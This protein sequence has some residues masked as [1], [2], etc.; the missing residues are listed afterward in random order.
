MMLA[1]ILVGT[2]YSVAVVL[3]DEDEGEE[4]YEREAGG[5]GGEVEES[6]EGEEELG[7]GLGSL[8]L[9]LGLIGVLGYVIYKYLYL[10]S[11]RN[12]VKLPISLSTALQAHIALSVVGGLAA[13]YHGYLLWGSEE[14]G[15]FGVAAAAMATVLLVSGSILYYSKS[16]NLKVFGK[17]IHAQRALAI[18]LALFVFLHVGFSG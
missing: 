13:L 10:W 17:L 8:A 9:Y 3:A 5:L 15:P 14:G 7:G 4:E 16:R 11:V 18:L 12:G 2:I 6:G 1:G